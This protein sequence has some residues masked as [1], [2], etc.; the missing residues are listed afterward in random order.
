MENLKFK[1][2]NVLIIHQLKKFVIITLTLLFL[3]NKM[4][5]KKR[6]RNLFNSI[7]KKIGR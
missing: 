1:I 7:R 6:C 2:L 4:N 3:I 5:L